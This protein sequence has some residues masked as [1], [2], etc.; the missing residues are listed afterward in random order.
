MSDITLKYKFSNYAVFCTILLA[1]GISWYFKWQYT[2]YPL[3][4]MGGD[5]KDYYSGL[6]SLFIT[7]DFTNQTGNDWFLL[8][9]TGGTINV[10]PI[11]VSVLL[12]PFFAIG[13]LIA[14]LFHFQIDGF[15][16]PFQLSVAIAALSAASLL[17]ASA[18]FWLSS[19]LAAVKVAI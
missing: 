19:A 11:G 12:L 3:N 9:T 15:S 10:H 6:V 4:F 5:A 13:S 1:I 2:E 16:F 8:K 7:H 18:S 14:Y 17:K